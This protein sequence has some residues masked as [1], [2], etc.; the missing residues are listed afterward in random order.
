MTM[1]VQHD[2]RFV[3]QVDLTR[4]LRCM[5]ANADVKYVGFLSGSTQK[6]QQLAESKHGVHIAEAEWSPGVRLLPLLYWFDKTH[7][8]SLAYYK[9]FVF[10]ETHPE[11]EGAAQGE[12][13]LV[14]LEQVQRRR[15]LVVQPGDFIEDALGKKELHEIRSQGMSAHAKYGTY[16]LIDDPA[17]AVAIRHVHGRKYLTEEQRRARGYPVE[18][19]GVRVL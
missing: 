6:Y 19:E 12:K 14:E 13:K 11:T 10:R 16:L 15:R 3:R 5:A 1:V 8:C 2:H 4:V 9:Q 18:G 7:V 17:H